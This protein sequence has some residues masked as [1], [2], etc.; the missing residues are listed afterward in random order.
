MKKLTEIQQQLL[1][2]SEYIW[3]INEGVVLYYF[4]HCFSV[5]PLLLPVL[6]CH[7]GLLNY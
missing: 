1:W 2:V 6:L 3:V 4:T 5:F 7:S